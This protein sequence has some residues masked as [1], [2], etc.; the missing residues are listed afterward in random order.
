[1]LARLRS[2]LAG[3]VRP[4]NSTAVRRFE[5]AASGRRTFGLGTFGNVNSE[6]GAAGQTLAARSAYLVENNP[7]IGNAIGHLVGETIGTGIRPTRFTTEFDTWAETSDADGRTDFYG[8]Q[9]S[10]FR[11]VAVR[12]ESFVLILNTEDGFQLRQLNP[13]QVDRSLTR[14]MAGGACIVQG[15]E[16]DGDGRRVAYWIAPNRLDQFASWAPP[17]RVVT[18]DVLH[19]F[20]PIAP[21]Q[22][23][24]I[25]WTTSIILA[26]SEFDKLTDALLMGASVAAMFCG[27]VTDEGALGDGVDPFE[28]ASQ[29]SLEPG[30]LLRLKGGQKVTFSTPQQ[31][32]AVGEF[33]KAQIR[34]LAAGLGVPAFMM[35]GDLSSANYSSL[36]AGLLP[37]RRRTEQFQYGCFV[38]QFLA[39]VW[40]RFQTGRLLAG[41]AEEGVRSDW[42]MPKPLQVDP[43]KD[44]ESDVAEINAGLA[45]RR[46]KV[47]ERG[48]AVESLD[49]EIAADHAREKALGLTFGT[50]VASPQ[51]NVEPKSGKEAKS[52]GEA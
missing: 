37:F 23:R 13:E 30:T 42:I 1:M 31:S 34:A 15:V 29:P 40:R 4:A 43:Q 11:D 28:G 51:K 17:I 39:P 24:G 21:G 5:G 44:I 19:V 45:S 3:M 2:R 47:A 50:P 36:R 46:Q 6:V 32:Q 7:L 16:F 48:W 25:P 35:D 49:A 14:E 9:A 10:V 41:E 52:D 22:V 26:A 20:R 38:P 33:V 18:E 12:G 27:V 8:L